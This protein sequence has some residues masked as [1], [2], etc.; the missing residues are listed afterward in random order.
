[1]DNSILTSLSINEI[2]L[3]YGN[4]RIKHFLEIYSGEVTAEA[5]ALALSTSSN[6]TEKQVSFGA[7]RD[8]IKISGGIIH[9]IIV[10][11]EPDGR[12]IVIEGNTR[13]QIYKDFYAESQEEKWSIIPSLVYERLSDMQKHEIRLQSHLVGPREWEPYSKAKYLWELSCIENIPMNQLID[14]CGGRK[15]EIK[16][17]IDTYVYMETFYRPYV[18]EH[19]Y[20]FNTREFSKF[21]EYMTPVVKRAI[22]QQG[23]EDSQFAEWVAEGNVDKA[24]GVRDLPEIMRNAE[25]KSVFLKRNLSSAEKVVAAAKMSNIDLSKYSMDALLAALFKQINEISYEDLKK[26]A[27]GDDDSS[28]HKLF[29]IRQLQNQIQFIID[30]INSF[31]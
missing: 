8:S 1:M 11:H 13:L 17:A 25:A 22:Q 14:L 7:L 3:D 28:S 29:L 27:D 5:I 23:F 10:S 4:P 19:G 30:Q 31:E 6:S 20:D 16:K 15:T 12:Y 24:L 18:D 2:E 9:P 21:Q 26:M